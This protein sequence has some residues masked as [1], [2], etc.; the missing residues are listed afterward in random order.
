MFEGQGS[1]KGARNLSGKRSTLICK[2][3]RKVVVVI[4]HFSL[5]FQGRVF[6]EGGIVEAR[7]GQGNQNY[8][9][10]PNYPQNRNTLSAKLKQ[11]L[12]IPDS[13]FPFLTSLMIIDKY[14]KSERRRCAL[15]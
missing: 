8:P 14:F 6:R 13:V 3:D 15:T 12:N 2:S 4:G 7:G 10:T 11:K 5:I 9:N 1:L